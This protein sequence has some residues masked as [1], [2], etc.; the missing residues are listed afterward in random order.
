MENP[1]VN[2]PFALVWQAF[3]NL[4]PDK[5]CEVNWYPDLPP[6]DDGSPAYGMTDFGVD[7]TIRVFVDATMNVNDAVEILAHELAHVAVGIDSEHGAV[8]EAAFDA[9]FQEYGRIGNEMFGE[10]EEAEK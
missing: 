7:G 9:I 2:D 3:K 10:T 1:F 8:W 5:K 4:Y 6:A